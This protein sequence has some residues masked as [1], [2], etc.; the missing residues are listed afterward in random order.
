MD[1]GSVWGQS[2]GCLGPCLPSTSRAFRWGQDPLSWV[3]EVLRGP[4]PSQDH[5]QPA[6]S[7]AHSRT[8]LYRSRASGCSSELPFPVTTLQRTEETHEFLETVTA[9]LGNLSGSVFSR[10]AQNKA[11]QALE[12]ESLVLSRRQ[13]RNI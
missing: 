1:E 9:L 13:R 6:L 11:L 3:A 12:G 8:Q 4:L 10:Q 2:G 7:Q 5:A